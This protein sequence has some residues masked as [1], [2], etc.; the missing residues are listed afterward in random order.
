M[1]V[2]LL[3]LD[4]K[5][6]N[7]AL[8]RI[9]AHHRALGDEIEFARGT[10]QV[11]KGLFDDA[12]HV[13]ASLIFEK[14]QAKAW[15]LL[16]VRPD[17]IIG[18][19]G[20]DVAK[21]LEDIGITTKE[22]DYSIYPGWNQ[23]VGR[24]QEG[25]RLKCT[26]CVVPVKEGEVRPVASIHDIWR[27]DPWPRE[28][29][30][31]DNDFFANAN[32]W[33]DRI[34]ELREGDFKVSFNQG[35]NA[36]FLNDETAAAVASVKYFDDNFRRRCVYTAWDNRKDERTLFRGLQSLVSAG[37]RRRHI[38]VY[39]L[40]GYDHDT[41][42]ARWVLTEDDFHRLAQL[43]EFGVLPYPMPYVRNLEL[44]GFQRWVVPGYDRRGVKW[45]DWVRARYQP[46]QLGFKDE[47]ARLFE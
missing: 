18:G 34:R 13:Y 40:I 8:M 24:T 45:G 28:I 36:R 12:D 17:A 46:R 31:L 41:D 16:K 43:R 32:P 37:V 33:R 39:M 21:T 30:L 22:K 11:E 29:L 47:S 9:A 23:S 35:I 38:T 14:T 3:Q 26:F 19:T 25:C 6:P 2:L 7:L 1:K 15:R 5:I 27:G 4:G 42:S 20:W 44:T 10:H